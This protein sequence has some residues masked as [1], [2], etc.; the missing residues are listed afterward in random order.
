MLKNA[1]FGENANEKS[2]YFWRGR[3]MPETLRHFNQN[4]S[5]FQPKRFDVLP[6]TLRRFLKTPRRFLKSPNCFWKRPRWI[7]GIPIF[8]LNP[9][10]YEKVVSLVSPMHKWLIYRRPV[11]T[12][13][14]HR[15]FTRFT[16]ITLV[17]TCEGSVNAQG[18]HGDADC[19]WVTC[20]W[21]REGTCR[22]LFLYP[23]YSNHFSIH[24]AVPG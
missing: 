3:T 10:K 5:A 2:L 14:F 9:G 23:D 15:A 19:Q 22:T 18:S 11:W 24:S 1:S 20:R 13:T 8:C 16:I 12:L 6:K 4:A 17:E 7:A 21:R